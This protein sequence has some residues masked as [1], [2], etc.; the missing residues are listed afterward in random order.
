MI[1]LKEKSSFLQILEKYY[2]WNFEKLFEDVSYDDVE[3][4]L[5]KE[6]LNDNDLIALLSPKAHKY[7]ELLARKSYKITRQFFGNVI[8]IYAPLYVSDHCVN[9]CLYCGFSVLE[10]FKRTTLP[11]DKV[12]EEAKILRSKGIRHVLL[13]TGESKL[14]GVEYITSVIRVLKEYFDEVSIEIYPMDEEDYKK[15]IE[16]GAEGLIVYQEVYNKEIYDKLH[17]FGP[18]KN[19][20][21][22]LE[23][24]DRGCRSGFRE[25]NIGALLGLAPVRREVFF[26]LKHAEYLF[27]TYPNVEIGI[28]FPRMRPIHNSSNFKFDLYPVSDIDLVQFITVARIFLKRVSINISTRESSTFRDNIALLGPTRMSAESSTA[29]GGYSQN[30]KSSQ[31]DISDER[32][33][34]EFTEML[35]SKGLLPT[36]VNW[37]KEFHVS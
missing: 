27:E 7:I 14:V 37:I 6:Y 17:L 11:L 18:K 9:A 30:I 16:S 13:L 32:T 34:Q 33:I 24:P 10:K 29:V 20:T 3:K 21:Y 19:Y 12:R 22:R 2:S 5:T 8:F 36:F 26:V 31:F 1:I 35:K 15:V 28:S 25:I 4:A 23:T